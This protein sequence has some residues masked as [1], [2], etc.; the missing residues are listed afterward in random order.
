[1][2]VRRVAI[3]SIAGEL[4]YLPCMVSAYVNFLRITS[5]SREVNAIS[6]ISTLGRAQHARSSIM[7]PPKQ[8]LPGVRLRPDHM[9]SMYPLRGSCKLNMIGTILPSATGL[10]Q[11]ASEVS[12]LQLPQLKDPDVA[13]VWF[14]AS[15]LRVHDHDGLVAAGSA[16]GVIPLYVFDDQVS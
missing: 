2:R 15:D 4:L 13:V 8:D 5:V 9:G 11:Q 10:G 1:M 7:F 16:A 14:T 6:A 3:V 12:V